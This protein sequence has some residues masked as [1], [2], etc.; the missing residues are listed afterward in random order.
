LEKSIAVKNNHIF[1]ISSKNDHQNIVKGGRDQYY[2]SYYQFL[3]K[4]MKESNR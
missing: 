4:I 2:F 1:K 3:M